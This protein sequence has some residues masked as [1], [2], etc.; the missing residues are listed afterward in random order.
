MNSGR[1]ILA[2]TVGRML[3]LPGDDYSISLVVILPFE[4]KSSNLDAAES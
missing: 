3:L 2:V 4:G 1:C